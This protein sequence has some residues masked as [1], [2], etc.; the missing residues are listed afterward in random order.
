ML[1]IS[2]DGS[3]QLFVTA[4]GAGSRQAGSQHHLSFAESVLSF[5]IETVHS[6]HLTKR[7][8]RFP[9]LNC[10]PQRAAFIFNLGR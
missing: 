4:A 10:I 2:F 5:S 6:D 1:I 7:P 3:R 8:M 9:S